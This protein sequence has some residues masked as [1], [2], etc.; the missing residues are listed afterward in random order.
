[1]KCAFKFA[2]LLVGVLLL[3]GPLMACMLS[4]SSMTI[5]EK[6]C[7]RKMA[8]QCGGQG[9]TPMSHGCCTTVVRPEHV[10]L[11]TNQFRLAHHVVTVAL[12]VASDQP[13]SRILASP[14]SPVPDYDHP[15]PFSD[16][17]SLQTLRI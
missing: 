8:G 14:F 15:P 16:L 7:C 9:D 11:A 12:V 1:V 3:A 5:A 13:I 2:A 10:P 6:E 4:G 17:A